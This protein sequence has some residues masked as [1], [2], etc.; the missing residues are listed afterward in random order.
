MS[1]TH[2]PVPTSDAPLPNDSPATPQPP[3]TP[4]KLTRTVAIIKHHALAHRF[5]LEPRIQEASFEIVKERQMEFDVET[6]PETLYELFGD[7][8]ESLG[9]GP[10]WVYVLERRRAVEVWNTLMG[11]PDPEVARQE[12]PNSLRA[13]YGISRQQNA[14]MGSPDAETAEIQIASLFASSPPF[15]TTDLPDDR[16][17]TLNSVS[18]SVLSALQKAT[19]DEALSNSGLTSP[20]VGGSSKTGK[21]GS[22]FRARTLPSTHNKP[23][24]VPRTTRAAALRAGVAPEKVSPRSPPT[25]DSLKK[26]F[27]NVP[28]HKRSGTIN[29]ASTAAPTI[30]PR[31]TK[32]AALR[33]GIQPPPPTAR[34]PPP[35]SEN[36]QKRGFDGVPGHKRRESI[37]VASVSAPTIAPRLNKSASLR[38]QKESAPPSSFMFRTPSAPKLPG[39]LS[40]SNSQTSL[41]SDPKPSSRPSSQA[42]MQQTSRPAT[43]TLSRRTSTSRPPSAMKINGTTTTTKPTSNGVNRSSTSVGSEAPPP[44]KAEE[45]PKPKPRPSSIGAPT[46]APRTNKSAALRAAKKEQEAAAAAAAAKKNARMSRGPPP[47]SMHKSLISNEGFVSKLQVPRLRLWEIVRKRL[48]D[49]VE[50]VDRSELY[51]GRKSAISLHI[52]IVGG[53]IGGLAAAYSLTKAGHKVT[54][55]ERKTHIREIGAGIM[56]TPNGTSLLFKWGL[57]QKLE[58]VAR[59][60]RTQAIRTFRYTG[61]PLSAFPMGEHLE[62]EAGYPTFQLHRADLINILHGIAAP[63]ADVRLGC[64]VTSINASMPSVTLKSGETLSADLIIG[65]DG[66]NSVVR[67]A[68]GN[69]QTL[70]STGD[71][72]YR[73]LIPAKDMRQDPELDLLLEE[74]ALNVWHGPHKR[75]VGYGIRGKSLFNMSVF[76]PDDTSIPPTTT[77]DLE[78][79]KRVFVEEP[80]DSRMR[81]LLQLAS[82][83]GLLKRRMFHCEPLDR[84][85]HP[86]GPVTLLGDS[87]HLFP[88]HLGQGTS[89]AFEDAGVLGNLLSR[90]TN[91]GQLQSLLHAYEEIRR[92]RRIATWKD[93]MVQQRLSRLPDGE[94]QQARDASEPRPFEHRMAHESTIPIDC[95][96]PFGYDADEVVNI[97]WKKNGGDIAQ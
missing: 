41:R 57:A 43:A 36:D 21:S 7:D 93:T 8:A 29:V 1:A 33:L 56:T 2:S 97:W 74:P 5:D 24:I 64:E 42:S 16:F 71:L 62:R 65:A 23:D 76:V 48:L 28:G 15:P 88:P 14:L 67:P 54:V 52:V 45:K 19:S 20:S 72:N 95:T 58:E 82:P 46:I 75:V 32:A 13:L 96:H 12:S 73:Y 47:S 55:L 10:V 6:D 84:W 59:S 11:N 81:K 27:E 70:K 35:A 91:Q 60:D 50:T 18:S 83:D 40:R 9:E 39:G 44:A 77:G 37:A 22:G 3:A 80:W 85:V 49:S 26:T 63:L 17:S 68:L 61:Q 78:A 38:A 53:G 92:P 87:C 66:A 30:A 34:K 79:M 4:Q 86:N 69:T 89:L 31:M 94:E 25:K 51:E 90:L